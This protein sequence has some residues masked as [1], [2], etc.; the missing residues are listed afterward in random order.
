ME[1][2]IG[3]FVGSMIGAFCCVLASYLVYLIDQIWT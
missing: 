1:I 2:I 3:L